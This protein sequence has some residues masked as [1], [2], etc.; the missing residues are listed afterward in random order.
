MKLIIICSLAFLVV[1]TAFAEWAYV[2]TKD[3][4]KQT[5]LIVV[6]R[7]TGVKEARKKEGKYEMDYGSGTLTVSEV[8]LGV[9]TNGQKLKLEWVNAA[10]IAC[11][12][13]EHRQHSDKTLIWLLQR[14]TNGAVMAGYPGRVLD[15]V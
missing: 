10:M 6:A 14:T 3:L 15:L 9:A 12:R 7:L 2:A 8:V 1:A 13:V 5:D 11:P 4:L